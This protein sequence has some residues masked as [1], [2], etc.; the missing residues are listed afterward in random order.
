MW[1]PHSAVNAR[2]M[3][4]SILEKYKV[5]RLLA[6]VVLFKDLLENFLDDSE[7]S[8]VLVIVQIP[9]MSVLDILCVP[10]LQLREHYRRRIQVSHLIQPGL[11]L[12]QGML[13][14]PK[15]NRISIYHLS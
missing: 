11:A 14:V 9:N 6:L 4:Q 5:H 13:V 8:E 7:V 1:Q 15:Q 10:C 12:L 3:L 2:Q